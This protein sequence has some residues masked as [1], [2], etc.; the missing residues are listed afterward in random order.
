MPD[1]AHVAVSRRAWV[2]F[3]RAVRGGEFGAD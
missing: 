1:G 2:G 3:V